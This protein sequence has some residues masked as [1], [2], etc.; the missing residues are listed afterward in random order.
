M[1]HSSV[2][3]MKILRPKEKEIYQLVFTSLTLAQSGCI[4]WPRVLGH[5]D[6]G[7]FLDH[8]VTCAEWLAK[9]PGRDEKTT[10][11]KCS[12]GAGVS[13]RVRKQDLG[14]YIIQANLLTSVTFVFLDKLFAFGTY[15]PV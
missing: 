9:K 5:G 4:R 2:V 6:Q 1:H 13:S 14:R 10:S 3:R 15:F 11:K 8:P 12:Q 7:A